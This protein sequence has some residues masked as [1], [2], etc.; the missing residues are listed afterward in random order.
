MGQLVK[1]LALTRGTD[2]PLMGFSGRDY[3]DRL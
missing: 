1:V 3:R 2:F